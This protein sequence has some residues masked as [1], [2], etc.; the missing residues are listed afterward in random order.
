MP[1]FIRGTS[2]SNSAGSNSN[3]GKGRHKSQNKG[4]ESSSSSSESGRNHAWMSGGEYEPKQSLNPLVAAART[5]ANKAR[6]GGQRTQS[7]L[8]TQRQ[9]QL[10]SSLH[11]STTRQGAYEQPQQQQQH[12]DGSPRRRHRRRQLINGWEWADRGPSHYDTDNIGTVGTSSTSSFSSFSRSSS[13]WDS[14]SSSSGMN[15]WSVTEG[16]GKPLNYFQSND[17]GINSGN[18]GRGNGKGRSRP[19]QQE[20]LALRGGEDFGWN[21]GRGDPNSWDASEWLAHVKPSEVNN[22]EDATAALGEEEEEARI[23]D[24]NDERNDGTKGRGAAEGGTIRD[25]ERPSMAKEPNEAAVDTP[26]KDI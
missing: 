2:S 23:G 11:N 25:D 16:A 24:I 1:D 22:H 8:Q 3:G 4:R 5:A 13:S 21:N 12:E 18:G 14:S 6:Q 20:E 26:V 9:R 19:Q 7:Q 15:E 10:S 17:N